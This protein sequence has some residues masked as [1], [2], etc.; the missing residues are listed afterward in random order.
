MEYF[1]SN[2]EGYLDEND[3]LVQKVKKD[4]KKM[5]FLKNNAEKN[6]SHYDSLIE[7]KK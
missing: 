6:K 3:S 4:N 7:D 1:I 2:F 5:K